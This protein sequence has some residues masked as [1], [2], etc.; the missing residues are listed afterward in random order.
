[1]KLS[2]FVL[3]ILTTFVVTGI[4]KVSRCLNDLLDFANAFGEDS[5]WGGYFGD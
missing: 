4:V 1:M 2:F 3:C 5:F